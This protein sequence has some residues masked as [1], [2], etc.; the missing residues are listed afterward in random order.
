MIIIYHI[1]VGGCYVCVTITT[2][3]SSPAN[4]T[5]AR[6]KEAKTRNVLHFIQQLDKIDRQVISCAKKLRYVRVNL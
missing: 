2:L 5:V 4:S 3:F 1:K 6:L